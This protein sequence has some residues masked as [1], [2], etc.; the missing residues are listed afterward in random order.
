MSESPHQP[1]PIVLERPVR[2]NPLSPIV[3]G[4][5]LLVSLVA[6]AAYNFRDFKH[7]GVWATPVLF[8]VAAGWL[9][10]SYLQWG[11]T[12]YRVADGDV[13]VESGVLVKRSRRVRIDRLQ[14]IDVVQP[15]LG[16]FLGLAELKLDMAG[17]S[18]GRVRLSYLRLDDAMKLRASLLAMAAGLDHET[19]EAPE[20]AFLHC[21]GSAIVG[22]ALLSTQAV[23][24]TLWIAVFVAVGIINHN[25][26]FLTGALPGILSAIQGVWQ[27]IQRHYGFTLADS[28]D[29]L[30]LQ[31]G[32]FETRAQT[33]PPGR[34][35]AV[36]I[37]QPFLWRMFGWV[38]VDANI[39]GYAGRRA[40]EGREHNSV[41]LPVGSRSAA[42][43]VI[44]RVLPGVDIDAVVM[45]RPPRRS[46]W[47]SPLMWFTYRAGADD[48]I[49]AV[50]SGLFRRVHA[51]I[52][53]EKIQS[54]RLSAGP[55][56]RLL[57]LASVEVHST[58]GPVEVV[59][60]YRDPMEG[61]RLLDVEATRARSGRAVAA[62]EQWM[63]AR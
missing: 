23:F 58:P 26:D 63:S 43:A 19:P 11:F 30:R 21:P 57:G 5:R 32:L 14:A 12:R 37:V 42:L 40:E 17:G 49:F 27:M 31:H 2:L 16:R 10:F 8:A 34:V 22:G 35:Q 53:H 20:V 25:L 51:V 52:R 33:V 3:R 55:W 28:P 36:R 54:V 41:L 44:S 56:E 24:G 9:A 7:L 13:R 59:A 15:L 50:R 29:G 45:T 47:H 48:A 62:P 4:G 1:L 61:R 18:E 39:A 46:M 60:R 6:V 38:R